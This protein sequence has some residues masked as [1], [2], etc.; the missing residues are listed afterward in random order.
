MG[1]VHMTLDSEIF[2]YCRSLKGAI[3]SSSSDRSLED[4]A[5]QLPAPFSCKQ[6]RCVLWNKRRGKG[7]ID[8]SG[9]VGLCSRR[10]IFGVRYNC[11]F[12][13]EE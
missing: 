5:G 1:C 13:C 8:V 10:C 9:D 2:G 6:K 11:Q 12:F 7:I 4:D 3:L